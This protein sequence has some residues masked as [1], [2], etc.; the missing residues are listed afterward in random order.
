MCHA[1]G[2]RAND[3]ATTDAPDSS[4]DAARAPS[5]VTQV[6]SGLSGEGDEATVEAMLLPSDS[7]GDGEA[8]RLLASRAVQ[9]THAAG[10][11]RRSSR[12][13]SRAG[14][15]VSSAGSCLASG[16]SSRAGAAGTA[17]QDAA[18]ATAAR[19][20]TAATC[21]AE[22]ACVLAPLLTPARRPS[23]AAA[24]MDRLVQLVAEE[25]DAADGRGLLELLIA[26]AKAARTG[27]ELRH[28]TLPAAV[29]L[30][31]AAAARTKPA[32]AARLPPEHRL[33]RHAA[34]TL[35]TVA[36]GAWRWAV[37]RSDEAAEAAL[38]EEGRRYMRCV[39]SWQFSDLPGWSSPYVGPQRR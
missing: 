6:T 15:S 17:V 20:A 18:T 33:G 1:G 3:G 16:Q 4:L 10:A 28:A 11:R 26:A 35:H 5:A 31:A 25:A 7:W 14:S 22:L 37:C 38:K 2:R 24:S 34:L 19:G 12:L 9:D 21:R 8:L 29:A 27:A 32:H 36:D 30:L 13:A 39:W 23:L